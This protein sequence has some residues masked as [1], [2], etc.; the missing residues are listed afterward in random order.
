MPLKLFS[1]LQGDI[2]PID[3]DD[4]EDD[5]EGV[6]SNTSIMTHSFIYTNVNARK[7]CVTVKKRRK[8]QEEE[9]ERRRGKV[10]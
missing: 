3:N 9:E 5:D 6:I 7:S 8:R 4:T 1:T 2:T 10:G